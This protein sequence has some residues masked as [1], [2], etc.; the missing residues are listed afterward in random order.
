MSR[1]VAAAGLRLL[2]AA[3]AGLAILLA[4]LATGDVEPGGCSSDVECALTANEPEPS[5]M[6]WR[7]P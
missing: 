6:E 3:C 7:R 4:L 5:A 1:R 2:L